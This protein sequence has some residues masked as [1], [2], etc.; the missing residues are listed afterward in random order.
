[1]E[2]SVF[3]K[4]LSVFLHLYNF[5]PLSFSKKNI[6]IVVQ[7]VYKLPEHQ[8]QFLFHHKGG[9]VSHHVF[10]VAG[11][12]GLQHR[13]AFQNC[14]E[15]TIPYGTVYIFFLTVLFYKRGITITVCTNNYDPFPID[16]DTSESSRSSVLIREFSPD[17]RKN[18]GKKPLLIC[19]SHVYLN[20]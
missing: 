18:R 10:V 7:A 17:M 5:E 9:V 4:C 16:S 13:I 14:R 11:R 15:S 8:P 6:I 19:S 3:Q 1:M 20:F 2:K 12:H